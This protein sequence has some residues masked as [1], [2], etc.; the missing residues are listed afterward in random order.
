MKYFTY[1]LWS[2]INSS[3]QK[4]RDDADFEWDA[5]IVA[6][7]TEIK[8]IENRFSQRFLNTY[9]NNH[10]FHDFKIVKVTLNHK[11]YGIINPISVEFVIT[12]G[13]STF[14]ITYKCVKKFCIK[15]DECEGLNGRRGLDDWG[16]SELLPIDE[17]TLS[18]EIL[19][20]SGTTILIHFANRNVFISKEKLM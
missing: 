10:Q 13:L 19:F 9:M 3:S 6:Y 17:H 14:K 18:H 7:T 1:K 20:R 8:K 11:D 5:N 16:Y 15:D 4:E 2:M 12:D